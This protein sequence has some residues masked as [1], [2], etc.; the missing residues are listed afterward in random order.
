MGSGGGGVGGEAGHGEVEHVGQ[1]ALSHG[2]EGGHNTVCHGLKD[3]PLGEGGAVD[4]H[5]A[6]GDA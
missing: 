1:D 5:E 3:R 6:G 2:V 4:Q